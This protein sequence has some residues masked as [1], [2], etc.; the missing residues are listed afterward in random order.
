VPGLLAFATNP[1]KSSPNG[2][3]SNSS[4]NRTSTIAARLALAGLGV[5]VLF[6]TLFV[7]GR[8]RLN[9]RIDARIAAIRAAGMPA[10]PAEINTWVPQVTDSENGALVLLRAFTNLH[11]FTGNASVRYDDLLSSARTNVWT[12]EQRAFARQYVQ[13]NVEAL[14]QIEAAL[15]CEKFRY[16][17]DYSAGPATKIPHLK[18]IKSAAQLLRIR[19]MLE[20]EDHSSAWTN[21]IRLQLKLAETLDSEPGIIGYFVRV[22]VVRIATL[23]AERA[24]N[25]DPPD[26]AGCKMLRDAFL[27]MTKTNTLPQALIGER[28]LYVPYFRMSRA[29]MEAMQKLDDD[30]NPRTVIGK[31]FF[32]FSALGFFESDLN[33]Y[34]TTMEKGI[35]VSRLSPPASLQLTNVFDVSQITHRKL[36][37]FSGMLLPSLSKISLRAASSDS[38]A[39][40]AAVAFAIEEFRMINSRLPQALTELTP[41]FREGIP[42]DPFDGKPIRYRQL[43]R[44]YVLYSVDADGHDNGGAPPPPRRKFKDPTAYDITFAVER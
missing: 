10:S 13:T 27:N 2:N 32:P 7:V 30:D 9:N 36:Y 25:I 28:A 11:E 4:A 33:F 17:V 3:V 38:S 12:P 18:N 19:T 34:L 14:A 22:A 5:T 29:D 35:E 15:R 8:I 40:L 6:I 21:S 42:I 1:W 39:K 20:L 37:I 24:L 23:S 43:G 44:G 31:S 26:S 41:Q 16:P